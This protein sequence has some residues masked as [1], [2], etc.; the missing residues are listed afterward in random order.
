MDDTDYRQ[1]DTAHNI[2]CPF[3]GQEIPADD[4]EWT[5]DDG[6]WNAICFRCEGEVQQ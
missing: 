5:D 2:D 6:G 3:C 1:L 4:F